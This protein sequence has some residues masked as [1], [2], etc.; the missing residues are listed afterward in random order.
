MIYLFDADLENRDDDDD[1]G[2]SDDNHDEKKEKIS[3]KLIRLR[4]VVIVNVRKL[5][6]F[7]ISNKVGNWI[8]YINL[9][10]HIKTR[11]DPLDY[12][13]EAKAS[14]DR[15]RHSLE[16]LCTFGTV[17]LVYKVFGIKV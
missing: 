9:P 16:A 10:L 6:G 3:K 2:Q 14:L 15:K 17:G 11:D 5:V 13:L 4:S 8:G 1:E 12:V 7:Q